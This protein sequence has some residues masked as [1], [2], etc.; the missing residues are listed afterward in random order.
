MIIVGRPKL[1]FGISSYAVY[2]K[3]YNTKS[4]ERWKTIDLQLVD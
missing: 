1:K 4:E 2:I 3:T